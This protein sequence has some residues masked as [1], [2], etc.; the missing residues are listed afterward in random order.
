[1]A[2]LRPMTLAEIEEFRTGHID[3]YIKGR[4]DAGESPETAHRIALAQHEEFYPGG[5]PAPGHH[6]YRV[7]EDSTPVGSLWLGTAPGDK[8]SQEWVFL[9]EI[10]EAHRGK[11]HGR[12]AMLLAE[13][14]ARRHGAKELGLNVW[15]PNKVARSLYE[16]LGYQTSSIQMLKPLLSP[17]QPEPTAT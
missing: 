13:E 6:H 2:T 10:D 3:E 11:G 5:L 17:E 9:V 16:S 14:E 7:I 4:V 12:A 8:P 15:G 1:M